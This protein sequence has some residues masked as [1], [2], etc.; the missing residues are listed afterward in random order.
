MERDEIELAV[1]VLKRGGVVAYPTETVYGLGARLQRS[2]IDRVFSLKGRE[3]TKPISIAVDSVDMM[4]RYVYLD[5]KALTLIETLAPGPYTF[6]LP[7][8][9]TVPPE[10]TGGGRLVG[11]RYPSSATALSLIERL[12]EPIT[13]TSA[14]P[15]GG[16]PPVHWSE[17]RLDVDVVIKGNCE[18]KEPS[19]VIEV[20]TLRILR[21][22]AGVNAA[23]R[24][25]EA[26]TTLL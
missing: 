1:E 11:V 10:L 26:L 4:A 3:R 25:L 17:V 9:S 6:V 8:R 14:N 23:E 20:D 18:Y 2:A 24:A 7:R 5:S 21:R 19:T 12:G 13:S 15:S 16:L 22:G